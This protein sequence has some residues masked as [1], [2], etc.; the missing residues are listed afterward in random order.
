[1]SLGKGLE[2]LI[3][4][5]NNSGNNNQG[6][7][8]LSKTHE[9]NEPILISAQLNEDINTNANKSASENIL[10][11]TSIHAST[12]ISDNQEWQNPNNDLN[13]PRDASHNILQNNPNDN[14]SDNLQDDYSDNSPAQNN[15][16]PKPLPNKEDNAAALFGPKQ[17]YQHRLHHEAVFQIE[18]N[19]IKPNP[20]Q[21]R[22]YFDEEA[23]RE[24]AASIREFGIIQPL[25]VSKIEYEKENGTDVEYQLIA[26][27]RR[28]MASKILG[29]ERVPAIVRRVSPG[30]EQMELAVVEN[31]QR[32]D[33][34][35]VE[36]ARAYAKLQDEFGLTQREIASRLGK[37]REVVAN[38][39]R[40]LNLPTEIQEALNKNEIN[41]SQARMLLA[42]D[43]LKTQMQMF[44]ELRA[45]K[46]SVREL[47]AKIKI[48]KG[49]QDEKQQQLS[50]IDPE[51][52]HL[53][54]Q[55]VDILGTKVKINPPVGGEKG[56]KIIISF[57]SPEEIQGIIEKF[58]R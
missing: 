45:N 8:V 28:L 22:K 9:Q 37:S 26:G 20:H 46:L 30:V 48:T 55:L 4:P 58:Q 43:D 25:V 5:Q 35:P 3:P 49:E 29:L 19:K 12:P 52:K 6:G 24:L 21:P 23:L 47:R 17:K 39:L 40:L 14:Y 34:S 11:Q 2:S 50:N 51:I 54:E 32:A 41:E 33:L 13:I 36:T 27:E 53:E 1:M 57:Y 16:L 10:P 31:L 42:I 38:T 44:N 7:D 56:G 15:Y 18:T